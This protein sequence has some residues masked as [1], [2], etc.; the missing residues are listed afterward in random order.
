MNTPRLLPGKFV[1]F[2]LVT[3]EP[4]ATQP[5]YAEVFGW[6]TVPLPM[7]PVT[8]EMIFLGEQMI[9]GYSLTKLKDGEAARWL[10]Y[11][12]V[13]DVD[14]RARTAAIKGGQI[15]ELPYDIP[16]AGRASRITDPQGAEI[17]LIK[18]LRDDPADVETTPPGGWLWNELHTTDP[19]KALAFYADVVGFTH[20]TMDMAGGRA[21]H[22]I[23]QGGVGRGGVTSQLPADT[24]PH[25]L[26]YVSA[27]DVDA[28]V[29]RAQRMG[30][31]IALGPMNIPTVGRAAVIE[32]PSGAKVALLK[33]S[34]R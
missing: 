23:S 32:D 12:S 27:D 17:A 20:S 15:R 8:Y 13:D 10:S 11:V 4:K 7:G 26:P 25:W 28:T 21:Y 6:K 34:P 16:N 18:R 9:G 19:V 33:P 3:R 14:A 5:F 2:E 24:K 22:V 30:G 29:A 1:W 31:T